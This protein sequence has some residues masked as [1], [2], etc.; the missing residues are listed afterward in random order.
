[1]FRLSLLP[2]FA[3]L[4]I[5]YIATPYVVV[6]GDI[7]A[8]ENT[9]EDSYVPCGTKDVQTYHP[10]TKTYTGSAASPEPDD[11]VDNPCGFGDVL[12]L[13]QRLIMGWIIAGVTF[14]T[15]GFAY[16]G[17]LY[18]TAMGSEEKV[19]HAHSI[20]TKTTW[21]FVFMLS[22]WLIAYTLE[23][24]FLKESFREEHSFLEGVDD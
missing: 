18:I 21:G 10:D 3:L 4:A 8:G 20:F 5:L 16:A 23:T 15:M 9:Y 14:A 13:A 19:S 24:I 22:A 7:P 12:V 1:M 2:F 17:Y 11:I 6:A